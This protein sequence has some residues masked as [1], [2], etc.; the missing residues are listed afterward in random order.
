MITD[1]PV[2]LARRVD[3]R[4]PDQIARRLDQRIAALINLDHQTVPHMAGHTRPPQL[5][6]ES[7]TLLRCHGKVKQTAESG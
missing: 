2:I 5:S 3:G 7:S 1:F 4:N 6:V